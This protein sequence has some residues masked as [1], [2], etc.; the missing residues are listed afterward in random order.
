[1]DREKW[2]LYVEDLK[3]R[4]L[5]SIKPKPA[6][7]VKEAKKDIRPS[8]LLRITH[9]TLARFTELFPAYKMHLPPSGV[10]YPLNIDSAKKIRKMMKSLF[11]I[12][13]NAKRI[14]LPFKT[15][16]GKFFKHGTTECYYFKSPDGILFTVIREKDTDIMVTCGRPP[17][18]R[19]KEHTTDPMAP[20]DPSGC[21]Y[22]KDITEI[23]VPYT[24]REWTDYDPSFE[25][26][27]DL[28]HPVRFKKEGEAD[29]PVIEEESP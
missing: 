16:K 6:E 24:L 2:R 18:E 28:I 7:I 3:K 21:G 25:L 11:K 15:V 12:F 22:L 5:D 20:S 13:V 27:R 14:L 19:Q 26:I 29:D 9:H 10:E 23:T 8:K 1:M 17:K 4:G